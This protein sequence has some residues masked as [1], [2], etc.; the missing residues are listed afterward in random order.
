MLASLTLNEDIKMANIGRTDKTVRIVVG[1]VLLGISFMTLGGLSTTLG[2]LGVIVGAVLVVTALVNF[3]PA[4]KLLGI[5][6]ADK[7]NS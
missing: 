7:S 6:T 3:C 2:I 4:Y 1:L 5:G